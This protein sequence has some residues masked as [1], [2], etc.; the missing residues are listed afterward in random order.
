LHHKQQRAIPVLAD[1]PQVGARPQQIFRRWK[2]A[3]TALSILGQTK[4]LGL[5]PMKN[6]IE[7]VAITVASYLACWG[8]EY[9]WNLFL[10][11]PMAIYVE[12][13]AQIAE[14]GGHAQAAAESL[15]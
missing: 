14:L 9:L 5:R 6:A 4:F 10:R 1:G 15:V 12:S 11:A 13:I 7:M 8:L 2:A 3:P